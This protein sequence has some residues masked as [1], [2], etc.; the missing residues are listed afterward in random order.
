MSA[1]NSK[2]VVT[3]ALTCSVTASVNV[4][5]AYM[6]AMSEL[7]QAL[8]SLQLM[9][10]MAGFGRCKV[11][12]HDVGLMFSIQNRLISTPSVLQHTHTL[13]STPTQR[14]AMYLPQCLLRAWHK[15]NL[16]PQRTAQGNATS[17]STEGPLE[18]PIPAQILIRRLNLPQ[19]APCLKGVTRVEKKTHLLEAP[20]QTFEAKATELPAQSA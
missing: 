12:I 2:Q 20:C 7:A 14:T 6:K 9:A 3:E 16:T 17:G 19:P 5:C 1:S 11:L 4:E 10:E 8:D 13:L 15:R 18:P